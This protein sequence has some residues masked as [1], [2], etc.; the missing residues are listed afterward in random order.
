M[1]VVITGGLGFLG[2][3]LARRLLELGELN[4]GEGG[5]AAIDTLVLADREMPPAAPNGWTPAWSS[6]RAT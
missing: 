2:L 3:R 5:P 4:L 1:K 6:R